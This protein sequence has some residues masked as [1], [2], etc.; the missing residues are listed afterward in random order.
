[1][2]K[3]I[4]I[5]L[6]LIGACASTCNKEQPVIQ[7]PVVGGQ[8]GGEDGDGSVA[9]VGKTLPAWVEGQM[10]I[11]FINTTSGESIFVI[12][13]DGT[14]M[15]I[16]AAGSQTGTGKVGSTTNTGIRSRW[17]P[18]KQGLLYGAFI[19]TYIRHC[20]E[21]TGNKTLDYVVL[22][23]FHNDHFGGANGL[24]ASDNSLTYTKQSLPLVL[25]NFTVGKLADRGWPDYNYPFDMA[26][27]A[28]NASNCRN[29]ITAVKWHAANKGLKV[30][31]FVA[32]SNSQFPPV[33]KASDYSNMRIQ[34]LA[35]NGEVWTGSGTSTRQT[36]PALADIRVADPAN[37]QSA[38]NCPEENHCSAMM[39]ISYGSFDFFA[40]GDA[41]Y[42]G[43]SSY[44]WKD[45]ETPVA[46]VC[47]KVE[48]MKADHHGTANTNGFGYKDTAWAMKYFQPQV[49]VVNSWTDGHPR[50]ATFEGVSAYL[51]AMDV[52][53]TNTC[54]AQ[55]LY[56]NYASSY[57][58]GN[59]HVVVR[60]DKGGDSYH[61][62]T[63][64]D[65]DGQYTVTAASKEYK[66]R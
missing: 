15:L 41:Q 64:T 19:S 52:Y 3:H 9:E 13:P 4:L 25:D 31:K 35:V 20:M 47:G 54:D 42:D 61:V 8:T 53:I 1:M 43:M 2:K 45:I 59:G 34:N 11:H 58:G 63:L 17:D 27:K 36:F 12:Y 30:E 26:T 22:T 65:S 32:G 66:S 14:Q 37:V 56:G 24:P 46:K 29:Y 7:G 44:A 6:A 18:S 10:D 38:D 28:D 40:G 55:K 57:K 62:Y 23:H 16:D 39:R 5:A 21:W 33:R 48:V 50:Q 51:P 49:W 60:V